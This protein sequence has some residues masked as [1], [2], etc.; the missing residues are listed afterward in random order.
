MAHCGAAIR[1]LRLWLLLRRNQRPQPFV[2][3]T[4]WNGH[5]AGHRGGPFRLEGLFKVGLFGN[6]ARQ[7]SFLKSSFES[8]PVFFAS[9]AGQSGQVAFVGEIGLTGDYRLSD[10]L[11]LRGGYQ[12][13]WIDGVALAPSQMPELNFTTQTGPPTTGNVFYHGAL[14]GQEIWFKVPDE[15]FHS[16]RGGSDPTLLMSSNNESSLVPVVPGQFLV[17]A[18]VT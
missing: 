15:S 1:E 10:R 17:L 4:S 9:A 8:A 12:L 14:S 11:L 16:A 7:N 6:A 2:W 18:G 5:D 13:L 3:R